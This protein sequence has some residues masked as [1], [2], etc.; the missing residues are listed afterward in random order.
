MASSVL[1]TGDIILAVDGVVANRFREVES[2][3]QKEIVR[4]TVWRAHAELNVEVPTAAL[5]GTDVERIVRWAGATL[6]APHRALASQRGIVPNGVFVSFFS[7]GSP[8]TR[9]GLWSGR[10]ITEV[11]GKPTPDLDSFLAVVKGKED[12]ASLRLKIASWNNLTEVIT[13]KLD[14][15]YWPAYE[16]V[17]EPS[18]WQRHSLE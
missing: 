12:R 7:Y 16:L 4:V 18:G 9:Y 17:R 5:T 6:Q 13:L 11:D 14:K 2:S 15:A 3:I 8:A 1:Q 10:R